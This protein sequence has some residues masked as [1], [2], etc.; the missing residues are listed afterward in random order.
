MQ[1]LPKRL[2]GNGEQQTDDKQREENDE[3]HPR[4]RHECGEDAALLEVAAP[5]QVAPD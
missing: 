2:V 1:R 3:P 5:R 4:E